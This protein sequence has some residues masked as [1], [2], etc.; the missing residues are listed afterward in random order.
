ME[1]FAIERQTLLASEEL[2]DH[3]WVQKLESLGYL[4]VY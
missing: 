2:C 4:S 1:V 3:G